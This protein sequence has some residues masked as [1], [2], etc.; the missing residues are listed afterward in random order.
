[1]GLFLIFSLLG[2]WNIFACS[3]EDCDNQYE[4]V[5]PK[6]SRARAVFIGRVIRIDRDENLKDVKFEISKIYKGDLGQTVTVTS[7]ST[8]LET[9]VCGNDFHLGEEYLVYAYGVVSGRGDTYSV[10][11]CG[12]ARKLSC[13][14]YEIGKLETLTGARKKK[15]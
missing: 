5:P 15:G 8:G 3:P 9:A 2:S 11:S 6:L 1:M 14:G 13:A 12:G 10:E 4:I 7:E